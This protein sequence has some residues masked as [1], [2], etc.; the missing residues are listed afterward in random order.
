MTSRYK[1]FLKAF[2]ALSTRY[3]V[4]Y[5]CF[6]AIYF[7]PVLHINRIHY[8]DNFS[9]FCFSYKCSIARFAIALSVLPFKALY[10]LL[11]SIYYSF[12][13]RPPS[14]SSFV[15]RR[16]F[17]SH[18]M[19]SNNNSLN[20]VFR[21][22][23]PSEFDLHVVTSSLYTKDQFNRQ[24]F[25]P[26]NSSTVF[27]RPYAKPLVEIGYII[28]SVFSVFVVF[29]D[30]LRTDSYVNR[31]FL[32]NVIV[33]LLSLHSL[34]P[35]RLAFNLNWLFEL[36]CDDITVVFITH[37]GYSWE[38]AAMQFFSRFKIPLSLY[39]HAPI[40]P[41]NL[42]CFRN[43]LPSFYCNDIY[44][45]NRYTLELFAGKYSSN[46]KL[47][48]IHV[49]QSLESTKS[50]NDLAPSLYSSHYSPDEITLLL[51]P[52]NFLTEVLIFLCFIAAADN[53]YSFILRLH[54]LTSPSD[55]ACIKKFISLHL[56]DLSISISS[57]TLLVDSNS[58]YYSVFRSSSAI[59]STLV[60]SNSTPVY[61]NIPNKPCPNPLYFL[62]PFLYLSCSSFSELS[63]TS[64]VRPSSSFY[65]NLLA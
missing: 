16:L 64:F 57:S 13:Y 24:F 46:F 23:N 56:S 47:P 31:L 34:V 62:P 15:P 27:C 59:L 28:S 10:I 29:K 21:A 43:C 5:S 40:T 9:S 52:E 60:N 30:L 7:L 8:S 42:S 51:L 3:S 63:S 58:S 44:V 32:M 39:C 4:K 20:H 45:Q 12:A 19:E 48:S 18:F 65:G 17:L 25:I 61:L 14:Y 35:R 54:P 53:S 55:I 26:D 41:S 2:H 11:N 49:Y 37:E 22:V 6:P 1:L 38:H 36:T 33:Q 50:S